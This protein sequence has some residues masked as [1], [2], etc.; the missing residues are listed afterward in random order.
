MSLA[1]KALCGSPCGATSAMMRPVF[2]RDEG[3]DFA[4]TVADEL[5]RHRLH[6]PR[7]QPAPH[8]PPEQRAQLIADQAVEHAPRLLR[9]DARASRWRADAQGVG[10]G[11]L[12]DLVELNP[13]GVFQVQ[14]LAQMPGDGLAFAIRVGGEVDGLRALRRRCAIWR[15]CPLYL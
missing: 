3:L 11:A 12:G 7:G 4:F 6:A 5:H 1:K 8:F 14:R 13:L 9:V 2:F 15:E 10:D